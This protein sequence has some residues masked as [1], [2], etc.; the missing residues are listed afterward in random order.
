MVCRGRPE[1]VDHPA[2][3]KPRRIR[4]MLPAIAFPALAPVAIAVGPFAIRWYALAYIAGIMIG[5]RYGL[6]LARR[7]P[8]YFAPQAIDDFVLYATIGIVAGGRLGYV[9]FYNLPYF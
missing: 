7:R 9:L 1:R 4:R 3:P 5:W 8:V 2:A 6:W